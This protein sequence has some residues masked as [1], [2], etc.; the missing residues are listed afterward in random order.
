MNALI[1]SCTAMLLRTMTPVTLGA[2]SAK[3]DENDADA[4]IDEAWW[5]EIVSSL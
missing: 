3:P 5:S 2:S 4:P 1:G